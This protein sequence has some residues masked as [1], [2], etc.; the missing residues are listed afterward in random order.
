MGNMTKIYFGPS[1]SN[2]YADFIETLKGGTNPQK[3][4]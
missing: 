1:I 2:I 4:N 3:I